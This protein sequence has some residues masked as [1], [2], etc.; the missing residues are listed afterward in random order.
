MLSA[1][2]IGNYHVRPLINRPS[3]VISEEIE[4]FFSDRRRDDLLLLYFSCHGIK[5]DAGRLYFAGSN[6]KVQRLAATGI[7]SVFV[8]EQIDRSRSRRKVLLLDCCYSGAFARGLAPRG[9]GGGRV[10]VREHFEGRGLA[11]ITASDAM[12]YAWE[13]AGELTLDAARPSIFSAAVINGLK[14]GEADRDGDG[15]ISIGDLYDYV[16]DQVRQEMPGQTPTRSEHGVQGEL[17][18]ARSAQAPRPAQLPQELQQ[19]ADNPFAAVRAGAVEELRQLLQGEDQQL[20]L[21]AQEVL[22]RLLREDSS[23]RVRSAAEDALRAREQVP[24]PI[25]RAA[26]L[27]GVSPG[28]D[29]VQAQLTHPPWTAEPSNTAFDRPRTDE[30]ATSR[31]HDTDLEIGLRW[32]RGR[33]GFDVTLHLGDPWNGI[34]EWLRPKDPVSIDVERLGALGSDEPAYGA[35][36]TEMVFPADATSFYAGALAATE[37]SGGK[38]RLRLRIDAPARFH[39]LWWESLRDPASG[40]PIATQSSVLLS[41]YLSNPNWP[42]LVLRSQGLRALIVVAGPWDIGGYRARGRLL[43]PAG[44]EEELRLAREAFAGFEVVGELA[45]GTATLANMMEALHQGVDVVLSRLPGVAQRRC[46]T[47]VLGE[48]RWN[49]RCRR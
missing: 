1:P 48:N 24:P 26:P 47:A 6:T 4:D 18:I 2:A 45:F 42:D 46:P 11:V 44:V 16:F 31:S 27:P 9:G 10:E 41:R 17:V 21:A 25:G 37:R 5:D 14:T 23:D 30:E 35:A 28:S 38:L 36:L 19:A 49:S 7:S 20:A 43:E 8:N 40:E 13:E 12:E 33:D 34:D 22:E 15:Q 39:A 32:D 29:S 3:S